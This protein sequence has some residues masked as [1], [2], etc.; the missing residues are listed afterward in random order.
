MESTSLK[1][2]AFVKGTASALALASFPELGA[3][4]TPVIRLEW[5]AF[6]ST[7]HYASFLNAV[8]TM[9]GV[10]NA[11][12]PTSWQYWVNVHL[13]YCPHAEPYFM[14]WHRGYIYYLEQQLKSTS[15]DTGLTLP[16]WDYYTYPVI[17]SEFTDTASGNPLYVSRQNT[18]VYQALD[19]SPFASTVVN[20]QRGTKN[21]FETKLENAPH[22][23]VHD[24][25]GSYMGDIS[26]APID[27]IF[28]LH[29][30][31]I[32]RLWNAWELRSTSKVPAASNS[33]WNGSFTYASGLTMAKSKT[34]TVAGLGYDYANDTMPKT[35]PPQAQRGGIVRV[36]AQIS[37]ISGRPPVGNF[38]SSPG[39]SISS[40]RRSL[41]GAK[42]VRLGNAS[43]SALIALSSSN[44]TSLKDTLAVSP[45]AS[46]GDSL[47][48][49]QAVAPGKASFRFVKLVLDGIALSA[50]AQNGGFFYNVYVNLP[51]TGDVDSVKADHFVG[52]VGAFEISTMK[53]HRMNMLSYDV[54]EQLARGGLGNGGQI[55][56][57]FVRI[58][59][60]NSPSGDAV[61]VDEVR[62]ELGT[63]AP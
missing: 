16:Y 53:H 31:N 34:R 22:N 44:A 39:R 3:A 51:A 33:Y 41:G 8:R 27:P 57:S 13:N 28:Y 6:K 52:T 25:I 58:S 11:N 54:T 1:R 9:K 46:P 4:V 12:S 29:H 38:T 7:P 45:A 15:G 36:Q 26:T 21:A 55:V 30:C 23:P 32:D 40:T 62:V 14:A 59:G 48:T 61:S 49:P 37:A 43:V 47:E 63:D 5:Q 10:T 56:V 20:M 42:G 2:R 35:L 17:P 19:L 50:A 60:L 24:I 18:N